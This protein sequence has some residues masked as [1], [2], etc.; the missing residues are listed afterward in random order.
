[1]RKLDDRA[2]KRW[3]RV[4]EFVV[5]VDTGDLFD[6]VD[7]ALQVEPPAGELHVVRA[8]ACWRERAAERGKKTF[9]DIGGNPL[10]VECRT[11]M[12]PYLAHAEANRRAVRGLR[13]ERRNHHIDQRPRHVTAALFDDQAGHKIVRK[14]RR[15]EVRAAL[16]AMRGV[17]M[18]PVASRT[19]ANRRRVE[20]RRFDENVP[21]L[22]GYARL[23]S[24][25][26]PGEPKRLALV[27]DDQIVGNEGAFGAVQ[28]LQFFAGACATHDDAAFNLVQIE[29]MGRL[30]HREP[31]EVGRIDRRG[32]RLLPE[33]RE[34]VGD[35]ALRRANRDTTNDARG[36]AAAQVLR[37]DADGKAYTGHVLRGCFAERERLQRHAID[38]GSLA[39]YAVVVHRVDAVGGDVHFVQRAA[40][41]G[42]KLAFDGDAAQGEV[43]GKLPVVHGEFRKIGAKPVGQDVHAVGRFL[44]TSILLGGGKRAAR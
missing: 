25:H 12:A 37:L 24:T 40:A 3:Q 31:T 18:Q 17:R 29:G 30:P 28:Q 36:E 6:Q 15:C 34:V 32:D 43:F 35:D 44:S 7:L 27:G 9:D 22:V 38:R 20:P 39:R 11:E 19:G 14:R 21:G 10:A 23:P 42:G 41:R 4:G 26:D 5:A 13:G 33:R 1:V 2:R 8:F 16:E